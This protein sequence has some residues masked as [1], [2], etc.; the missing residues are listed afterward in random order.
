MSPAVPSALSSSSASQRP[1]RDSRT[2]SAWAASG[3]SSSIS[4]GKGAAGQQRAPAS[5]AAN[6]RFWVQTLNRERASE[7]QLRSVVLPARLVLAARGT[8]VVLGDA[9]PAG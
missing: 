2:G 1:A 9:S 8:A 7:H 3:G 4:K 5:T 6:N